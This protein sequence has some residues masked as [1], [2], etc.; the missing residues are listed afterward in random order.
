[1]Q[2]KTQVSNHVNCLVNSGYYLYKCI[3]HPAMFS[4]RPSFDGRRELG[5]PRAPPANEKKDLLCSLKFDAWAC[6]AGVELT[7]S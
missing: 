5:I 1:M 4:P 7:L 6:W 3:F 2:R